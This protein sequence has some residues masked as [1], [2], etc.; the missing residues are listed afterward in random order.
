MKAV[1][2]TSQ[3]CYI[4]LSFKKQNVLN[5]YSISYT[6]LMS[7]PKDEIAIYNAFSLS[8]LLVGQ[9]VSSSFSIRSYGMEKHE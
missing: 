1:I 4:L 6:V 2:P 5:F 8:V 9:K 3:N 7:P